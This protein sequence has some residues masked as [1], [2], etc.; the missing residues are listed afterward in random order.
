MSLIGFLGAGNMAGSMIDGLLR[1][2]EPASSMACLGGSG[3]S[4]SSLVARTGIMHARDTNE[5]CGGADV[6]VVAFKPK[7]LASLSHSIADASRGKLV[8]SI[9]A[10]KTLA[11]LKSVFPNARAIVRAMP[12]TP[13]RIG[14]GVS[15]W[16]SNSKLPEADSGRVAQLLGALGSFHEVPESLMDAVTAVG[17]S[18]PGFVF[19]FTAALREAAVAA[20]F[21][22][23]LAD[24]FARSV[25]N[26]SGKLLEDGTDPETLRNQVTSP[27]GTT[28]AGLDVFAKADLRGIVRDAVLAATRRGG[29]LSRDAW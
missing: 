10:G 4:A 25:V 20:G 21:P 19:E 5:L 22:S 16:C 6:I 15:A 9:L 3:S 29:E 17:G 11:S 13:G 7:H 12:N 8:L 14:A 27:R 24:I 28:A 1:A 2:G 23:E 18:G 26:G